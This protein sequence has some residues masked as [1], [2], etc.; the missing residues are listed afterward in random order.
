MSQTLTIGRFLDIRIG[1]HVSWLAVYL[2]LTYSIAGELDGIGRP[3][4][5]VL[6]ALCALALFA[7]VVFHEFA[8]A[9]VA[10]RFGVNTQA[11]TLFL[12]GGV[13]TLESEPPSPGSEVAVALAGPAA[14]GLLALLA[15]GVL[16]LLD[17]VL[18]GAMGDAI[19]LLVAYLAIANGVL[20]VFNLLPSFPMDGGRVL[21]AALW[22][23]GRSHARA[24]ATATLVGIVLAVA[25]LAGGVVLLV[26][27]RAWQDGWY[28]LLGSFLCIQSIAAYRIAR[29]AV[30]AEGLDADAARNATVPCPTQSPRSATIAAH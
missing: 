3:I 7:S 28:I 15:F 17:P 11:I 14:S 16:R 9:L 12:F 23:L 19:A 22:R 24:T 10:R 30:A 2:F 13:A 1:I 8:H 25:V 4:A 20:A 6:G 21:R 26:L 18:H 27:D 5:F 29:R